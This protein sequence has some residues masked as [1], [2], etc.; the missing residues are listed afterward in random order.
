M[1]GSKY[2]TRAAPASKPVDPSVPPGILL[3]PAA[4]LRGAL[5][6]AAGRGRGGSVDA[7]A[8]LELIDALERAELR[9]TF[10]PAWGKEPAGVAVT[11]P[12]G[13]TEPRAGDRSISPD[14]PSGTALDAGATRP[15]DDATPA[16]AAVK[17]DHASRP[18]SGPGGSRG[19]A[20][21]APEARN[22]D[23]STN[24]DASD[25]DRSGIQEIG[26]V[27]IVA[28]GQIA[29]PGQPAQLGFDRAPYALGSRWN[30]YPEPRDAGELPR[31][32]AAERA[33]LAFE[34]ATEGVQ[35]GFRD[36]RAGVADCVDWL[37][38]RID[39]Q[40]AAR[41]RKCGDMWQVK[42][43]KECDHV[44]A[45]GAQR[46]ADCESRVCPRCQREAAKERRDM[47]GDALKQWPAQRRGLGVWMHTLTTKKAPGASV[48]RLREDGEL[49]WRAARAAWG[50]LKHRGAKRAWA[51]LEVGPGGMVHVHM[52]V[53]SP[54]LPPHALEEL[55]TAASAITGA[56]FY[57]VKRA[58]RGSVAE[59]AKYF[60]KGVARYDAG[61]QQTHPLLAAMV[62][63][64]F[65][66]ARLIREFGAWDDLDWTPP[67]LNAWECPCCGAP[68]Y[69]CAYM[70]DQQ[71]AALRVH[72]SA[73]AGGIAA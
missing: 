41:F 68:A 34:F 32:N 4:P 9:V 23:T 69:G 45:D 73:K 48:E 28:G 43:C 33:Q 72:Q 49:A 1:A 66:H 39:A 36:W 2:S 38:P 46:S 20:P 14:S 18:R 55:R 52:L 37:N 40:R 63:V 3:R 12:A 16:P 11:T 44:D 65:R 42:R 64:A 30:P 57:N 27:P 71:L 21:G 7:G 47:L 56:P 22:L 61:A 54:W 58:K 15:R 70:T 29:L 53:W 6:G 19:T 26:S 59:L 62:D 35:L 5:P 50:V 13:D 25:G 17:S 60:T 67:D 24:I 10:V 8:Q 51:K 31:G